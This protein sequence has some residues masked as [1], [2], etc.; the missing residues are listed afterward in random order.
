MEARYG[1]SQ[2][3]ITCGLSTLAMDGN[4]F[5]PSTLMVED[6]LVDFEDF[7]GVVMRLAIAESEIPVVARGG[8][9]AS[10]S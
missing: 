1:I 2:L 3:P 5:E 10:T 6:G 8:A 7:D 4:R 9:S